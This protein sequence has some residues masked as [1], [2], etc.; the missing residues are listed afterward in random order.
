[1]LLMNVGGGRAG[2]VALGRHRPRRGQ[3]ERGQH[4]G[5]DGPR[6]R[7]RAP[8]TCPSSTSGSGCSSTCRSAA[9]RCT[10][11]C[12][13]PRTTFCSTTARWAPSAR[14]SCARWSPASATTTASSGTSA[15]KPPTPPAQTRDHAQ[16]LKQLD[17]YDHPVALHTYPSQHSRYEAFEGDGHARR[18]FLSNER[19]GRAARSRPLPLRRRG[20]RPPRGGLS[21]RAGQRQ[22]RHGRRG[23]SQLAGEPRR[24]A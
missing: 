2:R 1:M 10:C 16:A 19:R 12:R 21:R 5:L 20:R 24:P 11:S 18:P 6:L 9:S 22:R 3:E 17:P 23:R 7:T 14:C 13:R 15:R 8:S 4:Q